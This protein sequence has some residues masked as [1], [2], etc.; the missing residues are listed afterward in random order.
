MLP[1]FVIFP[2]LIACVLIASGALKLPQRS[3]TLQSLAAFGVPAP[4]RKPWAA[5]A[6]PVGEI[7]LGAALLLLSGP[8]Y[9]IAATLAAALMATYLVVVARS[10][11][12]RQAVD[13]NCFGALS[14]E[15]VSQITIWRNA[16][17]TLAAL[18]AIFLP[19]M[20]LG[21]P[22]QLAL[23]SVDDW[24]WLAATT[25]VAL[26]GIVAGIVKPPVSAPTT[27]HDATAGQD[28]ELVEGPDLI[29]DPAARDA[30]PHTLELV[31]GDGAPELLYNLVVVPQKT[32]ILIFARV[33][34]G[35]CGPVLSQ[36]GDWSRRLGDDAQII[37][38]TS[39]SRASV[40]KSYPSALPH[41]YFGAKAATEFFEAHA[42]PAAILL[43]A[44]GTIASPPEF[45][46]DIIA[47][48]VEQ[49]VASFAAQRQ[50]Q[51]HG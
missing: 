15:P 7:I 5:V 34:C 39:S 8:A 1:T 28:F 43:A 24:L 18:L 26:V 11:S 29:S 35:S 38:A 51:P 46:G 44:D 37:V 22:T 14:T 49:L 33:G 30:I 2:A 45:G 3:R 36:V 40:K 10:V 6:L 16:G 12:K 17:L 47:D 27:T 25:T 9:L 31:S 41:T 50:S 32:T 21:V 20:A 23:F 13:C 42:T 48:R 19:G 4:L